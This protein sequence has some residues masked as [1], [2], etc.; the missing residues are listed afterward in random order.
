MATSNVNG[1]IPS[2][3]PTISM[4]TRR[5]FLAAAPAVALAGAVSLPPVA[6]TAA[7]FDAL[8]AEYDAAVAALNETPTD[9]QSQ[10]LGAAFEAVRDAR[11]TDPASMGRQL[12]WFIDEIGAEFDQDP[13][14]LHIADRLEALG[15][16]AA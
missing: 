8:L 10:R 13:M 2:S 4:N 9:E 15:S 6:E 7:G 14:L 12:R 16:T 11:P 5:T 1:R 3:N